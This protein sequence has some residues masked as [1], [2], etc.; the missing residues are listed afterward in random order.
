MTRPSQALKCCSLHKF[1]AGHM[2]DQDLHQVWD[3]YAIVVV[4]VL[5]G[6]R[7]KNHGAQ[8]NE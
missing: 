3:R 8:Y 4:D 1:S 2:A 6:C 5:P 7:K